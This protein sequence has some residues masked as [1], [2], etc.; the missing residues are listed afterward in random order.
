MAIRVLVI[1]D[2]PFIANQVK[3]G[4]EGNGY[5]VV[6]HAR[7]GE[8][9]ITMCQE[10][11]PD[12]VLLDII[13]PGI[14]GFETAQE[15]RKKMPGVKIIMLSSLCDNETLEEVKNIG[16]R[17]LIPKPLEVDMLLATLELALR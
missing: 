1:D 10:L 11:M 7:S 9:G 17:Y 12:M 2:S 16:L 5:T 4:I 15:I 6:G 13:M 3:E 8:E 14:D